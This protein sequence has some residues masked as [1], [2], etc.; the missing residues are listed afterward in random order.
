MD[1]DRDVSP[2]LDFLEGG[3][4]VLEDGC[5]VLSVECV[6][7][8]V[9]GVLFVGVASSSSLSLRCCCNSR[10]APLNPRLRRNVRTADAA[11]SP[12]IRSM[13]CAGCFDVVAVVV[14]VAGA[15]GGAGV[16]EE[17]ACESEVPIDAVP[18]VAVD[19]DVAD[20]SVF[21]VGRDSCVDEY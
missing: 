15:L 5:V 16:A 17:A 8:S 4:G 18:P 21:M 14:V 9:L 13:P 2:V 20:G 6:P 19:A 10:T 3:I 11:G 7:V 1:K 12:S